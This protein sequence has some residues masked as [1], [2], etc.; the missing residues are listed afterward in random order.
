MGKRVCYIH[1][2][3]HKSGTTA[4]QWFLQENR[5]ELQ[6]HGYFVP[7]SETRRGAHHALVESLAGLEIGAHREPLAERSIRALRELPAEAIIISSEALE[8]ILGSRKHSGAFFGRIAELN[9]EPKLVLFPRNQPQWINSSYASSVKSFR[10]S[11]AFQSCA[12]AFA[13]SRAATFLRWVELADAYALELIALPFT[14]E[15]MARSVIPE[16]LRSIG[17]KRS[18]EFRDV[19]VRRHKG[20]GPFTVSVARDVLRCIGQRLTWLQAKRCKVELCRYLAQKGLADAGY[21]GLTSALAR[22]VEAELRSD[23]NAFAKRVWGRPWTEVFASDVAEEFTPNDFEMRR[24][25][26]LTARRLRKAM[27]YMN[28]VMQ[29][30]LLDP[31]LAE[32][33]PWNDVAQ[34]SGLVSN[35]NYRTTL[36][37]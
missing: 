23:N 21:C 6:K 29:N 28:V 2:G 12:L 15:T 27:R 4:I 31:A 18:P 30:I 9:L 7:E 10:R 33:E 3:P 26:W 17:I 34:R 8:G 32:E 20:V 11:D 13:V 37:S 25:D 14:K 19:Q 5:S 16:F 1:A 35:L 36:C 22:H 24:P